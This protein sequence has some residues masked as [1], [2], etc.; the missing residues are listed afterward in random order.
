ML[1][2]PYGRTGMKLVCARHPDG[3]RRHS[4]GSIDILG[5]GIGC[6]HIVEV[7]A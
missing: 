3:L 1:D 5:G 7:V 4:R 6:R 2:V